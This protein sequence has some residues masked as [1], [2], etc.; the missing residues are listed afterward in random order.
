MPRV[1]RARPHPSTARSH[2]RWRASRTNDATGASAHP[3][4]RNGAFD[5]VS[6]AHT[7]V[8]TP[9]AA[10]QSRS[11]LPPAAA[12]ATTSSAARSATSRFRCLT[13]ATVG[14]FCRA[15]NGDARG[16]PARPRGAAAALS[17]H[18]F[19]DP[20]DRRLATREGARDALRRPGTD[21]ETGLVCRGVALR[22]GRRSPTADRPGEAKVRFVFSWSL[23]Y[24]S[25][26]ATRADFG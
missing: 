2:R 19:P 18:R 17:R 13:N 22:D 20:L 16:A 7:V 4:A 6:I 5:G 14:R 24:L 23:N 9:S 12:W 1:F 21:W 3:S 26:S 11:S 8:P 15:G 25:I 10:R